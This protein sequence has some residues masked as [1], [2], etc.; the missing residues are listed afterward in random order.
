MIDNA[1]K[2]PSDAA[3]AMT[4]NG[5]FALDAIVR[6]RMTGT[7]LSAWRSGLDFDFMLILMMSQMAQR[8]AQ[9]VSRSCPK[10]PMG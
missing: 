6:L 5:T 4:G 1:F 10:P 9:P 7:D 2:P 8:R 3:M